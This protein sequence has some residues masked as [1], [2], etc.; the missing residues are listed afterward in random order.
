MKND[1][2]SFK[3]ELPEEFPPT[4]MDCGVSISNVFKR[5]PFAGFYV[6]IRRLWFSESIKRGGGHRYRFNDTRLCSEQHPSS[7][8][9]PPPRAVLGTPTWHRRT[10]THT[11][12]YIY[13]YTQTHVHAHTDRRTQT[14]TLSTASLSEIND[15]WRCGL[16]KWA[17]WA[18][19]RWRYSS[20][21]FP[22]PNK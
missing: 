8:L 16:E 6:N 3:W 10:H 12:T 4:L 7:P 17:E 2:L 19:V 1:T 5:R 15:A 14:C 9:I 13:L 20:Q 18:A 22:E 11:H 21:R